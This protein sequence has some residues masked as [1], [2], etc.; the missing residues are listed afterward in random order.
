[1]HFFC[2]CRS[3]HPYTP[4]HHGWPPENPPDPPR[5][6]TRGTAPAERLKV[7]FQ[8]SH[9]LIA[10]TVVGIARAF[11]FFLNFPGIQLQILAQGVQTG[12][13]VPEF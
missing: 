7:Y 4:A 13:I 11:K 10:V 5:D 8:A 6:K 9:K 1:M 3:S 12:V 2:T